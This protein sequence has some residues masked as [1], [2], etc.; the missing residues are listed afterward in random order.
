MR[1]TKV[2][3][4]T[5]SL[6]ILMLAFSCSDSSNMGFLGGDGVDGDTDGDEDQTD[7][8]KNDLCDPD[9]CTDFEDRV[10]DSRTGNCVCKSDFC[11]IDGVCI[12]K[13][14][15]HPDYACLYCDPSTDADNWTPRASGY[16]CRKAEGVC[17]AVEACDGESPDCPE[18]ARLG[19]DEVCRE[20]KGPCDA[21]EK[22]DG[23]SVDCPKDE[24]VAKNTGCDDENNC[25][26]NDR[27]ND[28]GD[29]IGEEYSCNG[30]GQCNADNPFCTCS[31][32]NYTGDYCNQCAE[33]YISYPLCL[34]DA[35]ADGVPEDDGDGQIDICTGGDTLNCDDNC[36]ALANENQTDLDSDSLGDD[37]DDDPPGN[38]TDAKVCVGGSTGSAS[39]QLEDPSCYEA[40]GCNGDFERCNR[41]AGNIR[42]FWDAPAG[43]ATLGTGSPSGYEIH[44]VKN[45]GCTDAACI[46]DGIEWDTANEP[47]D[48]VI[49]L[50]SPAGSVHGAVISGL[51]ITYSTSYC[52]LIKAFDIVGNESGVTKFGREVN[53]F[54]ENI[55][56]ANFYDEEDGWQLIDP[57]YVDAGDFNGDGMDD[58]AVGAAEYNGL[59]G[60]VYIYYGFED[61]QEAPLPD[62]IIEIDG[63][64]LF[65]GDITVGNFNG[66]KTTEG[67]PI[68]DIAIG[69]LGM[70]F[71]GAVYLYFGTAGGGLPEEA[72]VFINH[73]SDNNND[74]RQLGFAMDTL[75]WNGD[76]YSDLL[77]GTYAF[78]AHES[79]V[80]LFLGRET[81]NESYT[82]GSAVN[83]AYKGDEDLVIQRDENASGPGFFGWDIGHSDLDFDGYDEIL[84]THLDY[85]GIAGDDRVYVMW[86]DP[87]LTDG[88]N[89]GANTEP[90]YVSP[91][92]FNVHYAFGIIIGHG[93]FGSK[94]KG[95]PDM[96][97]QDGGVND[98]AGEFLVQKTSSAEQIVYLYRGTVDSHQ[99]SITPQVFSTP[100]APALDDNNYGETL[101]NAGDFNSDGYGDFF[102]TDNSLLR[103]YLGADKDEVSEYIDM[104][105]FWTQGESE[106]LHAVGGADFNGDGLPDII[107]VNKISG[108][109]YLLK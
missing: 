61:G 25:T 4:Y 32:P 107:I 64:L 50:D 84:L 55:A 5:G 68:M 45:E 13:R 35:D 16:V 53:F 11:D 49:T 46:C 78:A 71:D 59:A 72:D 90:D 103:I 33:N 15:P 65:G 70:E 106:M 93:E 48:A 42:I 74:F 91:P 10:C 75:N 77:I 86:G 29:C 47:S 94:V 105:G 52:I 3:L 56:T 102:I 40:D 12:E 57:P 26:A 109:I 97:V 23:E 96:D 83:P 9:P 87:T 88:I 79:P 8:I 30:H 73:T 63:T 17:D 81:W 41:R 67:L 1:M 101:G 99:L 51:D 100:N 37:C 7:N 98:G 60:A 85:N 76:D 92:N 80:Y 18:D 82:A 58:L 31:G 95:L 6:L 14:T 104:P 28:S 20:A 62:Q 36:P 2:F 54:V 22:C 89:Q 34:L 27:C 43:N 38:V 24:F 66:D 44:V 19:G 108:N 21:A 69:E 39:Y